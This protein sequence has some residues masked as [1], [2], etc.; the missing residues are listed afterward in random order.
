MPCSIISMV[1]T[2]ILLFGVGLFSS[3]DRSINYKIE[4]CYKRGDTIIYLSDLYPEEWDSAYFITN[5]WSLVDIVNYFGP[6]VQ[7]YYYDVGDRLFLINKREK[8]VYYHEWF[9]NY[10]QKIKGAIFIYKG[11]PQMLALPRERA[12][13]LIRKRDEDS[14]WVICQ[15]SAWI[16]VPPK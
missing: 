15:D 11:H 10:G 14:F 13:F 7:K 8:V 3:C 16:D 5:V 12:K 9:V 4:Q 2:I 1:I 6:F